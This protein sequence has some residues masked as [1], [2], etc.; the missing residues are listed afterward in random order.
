VSAAVP[1][2]AGQKAK[3]PPKRL[4][5]IIARN[6]HDLLR[7]EELGQRNY[8]EFTLTLSRRFAQVGPLL[9]SLRMVNP[10]RGYCGLTLA[11]GSRIIDSH[12]VRL[13]Q[14]IWI[15][16]GDS[17][18]TTMLVVYSVDRYHVQGYISVPKYE[19]PGFL[20]RVVSLNFGNSYN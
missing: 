4:D 3:W 11:A 20:R 13:Y 18:R 6:H 7:L 14:P 12:P 9:V 5:G 1:P 16:A 15:S 2:K 19:K 8:H 10:S 17:R